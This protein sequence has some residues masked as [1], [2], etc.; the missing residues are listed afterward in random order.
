MPI[1]FIFIGA[2]ALYT[3]SSLNSVSEYHIFLLLAILALENSRIHIHISDSYNIASNVERPIDKIFS[4]KPTLSIPYINPDDSHI[5]FRQNFD[6]L[7]F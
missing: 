5:R 6:N 3:L 1:M 2:I 4:I 7:Q